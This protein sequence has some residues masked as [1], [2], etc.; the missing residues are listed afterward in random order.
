MK[1]F[2]VLS[3]C[4]F[5][6][7]VQAQI[8]DCDCEIDP[9]EEFVCAADADGNIFPVPNA[10]FAECFELSIVDSADCLGDTLIYDDEWEWED[11]WDDVFDCDCD[12]ED[13]EGEGICIEFSFSDSL[14]SG[15]GLPV[16]DSVFTLQTWVPSECF[17]DCWGY[18]DYTVIDC[19]S[20]E[21]IWNECDSIWNDD[22]EWDD[23]E[24]EDPFDCECDDADWEGEGICIEVTLVDS[25]W[26][27]AGFELD[28][29]QTFVTWVPSECFADCWGYTDFTV[30]SC[31]SL[32][33]DDWEWDDDW[34]DWEWD[35]P[36]DCECDE[37]DLEGEGIC[38]EVSFSDSIF[39]G[40]GL[41]ILDSIE[42]FVTW[43]PSE[44]F[45]DCYG[46]TDY[47]IVDCDS[48]WHDD[49][50]WEDE[51]DDPYDCECD[52]SDWEGEGICIEVTLDDSLFTSTGLGFLDSLITF[53]TWVPSECFAEC[54]GYTDYIIVDC[55][56]IWNDDWEWEDEW[57]DPFDCECD[58]SDWEGEGICIEIS[59]SD[60]IWTGTGLEI[61]DS[62]ETFITWV[63]SECF[64]DCWGYTDY[65]VV[66]CDSIIIFDPWDDC[67]CEYSD[68]DEP[69]CVLT[70]TATGEI[71]PFPNLCYA[72]CAG[73]TIDDVVDCEDM[74]SFDCIECMDE[75]IDPVCVTD[76]TGFVFPVPN[77]CFAD[78]LGLTIVDESECG[79]FINTNE[80]NEI[81]HFNHEVHHLKTVD[82]D[83][84]NGFRTYPNPVSDFAQLELDMSVDADIQLNLSNLSGQ[85]IWS[86]NRFVRAGLNN[87]ELD[88]QDV[89]SG[90]YM[91]IINTGKGAISEKIIKI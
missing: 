1:F 65:T 80:D 6:F 87:V 79:E 59:F 60:S 75:E 68:E 5:A 61:L 4:F 30:V 84:L 3:F 21:L 28:S 22:W 19:D 88:L 49:W 77:A 9:A 46:Y 90:V 34:D 58:E 70:D 27:P 31:D 36:F 66:E 17:A 54:W 63:P 2:T 32:W 64:A 7:T 40:T 16:L 50:E 35:D 37:S 62:I 38:I 81:Q 57:D 25:I 89:E 69:V 14:L 11:G 71:C 24:W 13:F 45:A 8:W 82:D 83:N 33:H 72:E 41:E 76:S 91:L 44:C 53:E 23:W 43:V 52:E 20:I 51:W 73:Y 39:A 18:T 47:V 56:S 42:T 15:L 10:C 12:P 78:C 29:T 55:D 67:D 48:T 74:M 85:L 86:Q 26:T